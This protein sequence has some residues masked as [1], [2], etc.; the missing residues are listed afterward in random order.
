MAMQT[1][2]VSGITRV[3]KVKEGEVYGTGP[4][5]Q[6]AYSNGFMY[7]RGDGVQPFF[8]DESEGDLELEVLKNNI[9]ANKKILKR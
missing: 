2:D 6:L 8:R 3:L 9:E 5:S 1:F 7:W 4:F